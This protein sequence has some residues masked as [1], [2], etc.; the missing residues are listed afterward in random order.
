[1]LPQFG[2]RISR[3][4]TGLVSITT[5]T[6]T[7]TLAATSSAQVAPPDRLCDNSFED[8]RA[9]IL[10]MIR[11][12][13]AGID[14]SYWFMTDWRYSS[15]I[16]KRWQAG[17]PVRILLDLRADGGYPAGVSIRQSFI[18]AGIPIRHKV[19][20]GIN[21]WKMM[22]YRGQSAVHFS[23]ANF[24]NGSYSPSEAGGEYR[25]YVDEAIYFT[26]D[27]L[28]VLPLA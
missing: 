28:V 10:D 4:L 3:L 1:M 14:V 13:K 19:T 18:T 12:E 23:A 25:R 2:S 27:P 21:H 15:E 17:V 5:F 8:C 16:I 6:L 11:N 9:T 20:T 22:L 26:T 7:L 24:S